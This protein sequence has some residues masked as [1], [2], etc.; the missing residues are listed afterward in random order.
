MELGIAQLLKSEGKLCE[1]CP[2][3]SSPMDRELICGLLATYVGH[4]QTWAHLLHVMDQEAIELIMQRICQVLPPASKLIQAKAKA[5]FREKENLRLDKKSS[6]RC[7]DS[8]LSVDSL[9]EE[10]AD[11]LSCQDRTKPKT[12]SSKIVSFQPRIV[13]GLVGHSKHGKTT[14][15]NGLSGL[16]VAPA[17]T[18]EIGFDNVAIYMCENEYCPSSTRYIMQGYQ[19]VDSDFCGHEKCKMKLMRRLSLIDCP[20][21]PNFL[22]T[23]LCA[24]GFMDAAIL[25]ISAKESCGQPQTSEHLVALEIKPVNDIIIVQSKTDS[26]SKKKKE[27]HFQDIK[28]YI[29]DT[30]AKDAVIVEKD[31][32][33]IDMVCKTIVENIQN[34]P[35]S[36]RSPPVMIIVRSNGGNSVHKSSDVKRQFMIHGV[37]LKGILAP[38]QL[39]EIR[40]GIV[41]QED[42]MLKHRPLI[43]ET[44]HIYA[45]NIKLERA[46]P[47]GI[48]KLCLSTDSTESVD[49]LSG[50]F[51]GEKGKLPNVFTA[52]RISYS[53]LKYTLGLGKKVLKE[54]RKNEEELSAGEML[55]IV[56]GAMS[57]GAIVLVARKNKQADL[58]L[59]FPVCAGKGQT[60]ML[61]RRVGLSWR[62]AGRASLSSGVTNQDKGRNKKK[63]RL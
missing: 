60:I 36:T 63:V 15:R 52:F 43:V 38:N 11:I 54:L 35:R 41:F 25:L 62:L 58:H 34:P 31:G 22:S 42:G 17:T 3:S 49:S 30:V 20:G 24:V 7:R 53:L 56:I 13:I 33:Y 27:K 10:S 51:L 4:Q 1:L 40:P 55:L 21:H 59:T 19:D 48:I 29:K 39:M 16:Q 2:S 28:E 6:G 32:N 14:V 50:H 45:D 8:E 57:T 37:L 18:H 9:D 46:L 47:G 23:T 61:C 5:D 12:S 26:L 44:G